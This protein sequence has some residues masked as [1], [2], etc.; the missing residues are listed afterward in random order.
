MT[1]L[2]ARRAVRAPFLAA[3]LVM[4]V[5][6]GWGGL[7]RSGWTWPAGDLPGEHG[8]LMILGF[9]GTVIG[10]ERAVSLKRGWAFAAPIA[11]ALG[12]ILWLSSAPDEAAQILW[13]IAGLGLVAIFASILKQQPSL[14]G[15]VLLIGALLWELSAVR[16]LT[17]SPFYEI[18]PMLAGSLVVTIAGERLELSRLVLANGLARPAFFAA[19]GLHL[20]GLLLMLVEPQLGVQVAGV[21]LLALSAWLFMQDIARRTVRQDGVTRFMAVALLAGYVWMTVGGAAWLWMGDDPA[22]T[23]RDLGL[24]AVLVGFVLSMVFAHAP[25]VLA[26]VLKVPLAYSPTFWAHLGVLHVGMV[27]RTIGDLAANAAF[28]RWGGLLTGIALL[29]FIGVSAIAIRRAQRRPLT[30]GPTVAAA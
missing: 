13:A 19:L 1:G 17:G 22:G 3:A 8:P 24:H 2:F 23:A 14:H 16:W 29:L 28:L 11:S 4:A 20:V 12:G 18:A 10:M 25:I 6:A 9:L 26:A 7:A 5:L 30:P 27:L 21:G 15:V